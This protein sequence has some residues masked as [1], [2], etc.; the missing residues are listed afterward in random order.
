MY[1]IAIIGAGPAGFTAAIYAR[2]YRL[3][4]LIIGEIYGGMISEAHKVCNFPT[5]DSIK[6]YELTQK[7]LQQVQN[8]GAEVVPEVV[9]DI[10]KDKVFTV[11]TN[12]AKYQAKKVIIAIGSKKRKL[13]VP[14]ETELLGK[15]VS[16]CATCDAAF[17]NGKTVAVIGG[18]NSALTAALLLAEYAN[19]VYLIYR[20]DNFFRAEPAWVEQVNA[21]DKI[22]ILFN[23]NV[24]EILG[25]EKVES[26]KT[27][28]G[29]IEVNGVFVEIGSTPDV[30][31]VEKLG[32]EHR[33]GYIVVDK[34]QKTNVDG[35]YAAGDAT[36]NVLKQVITACAE[37]AVAASTAYK[38]MNK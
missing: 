7:M 27:T 26:V 2:R 35:I 30:R 23:T 21:N 25:K 14:G 22:E 9:E 29:L 36:D 1:D 28:N 6:G 10:T 11:K 13:N 24:L 3:K 32:L 20:K 4:T 17:F 18:S 34:F 19:K 31:F 33:D 5:Y 8:L 37:G 16:Y 15:G 12:N 38:E